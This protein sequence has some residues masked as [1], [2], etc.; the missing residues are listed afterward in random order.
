MAKS[1]RVRGSLRCSDGTVVPIYSRR[2]L[3]AIRERDDESAR[4]SA[5]IASLRGELEGAR[6]NERQLEAAWKR[7][8][9]SRWVR[10]GR[11]LGMVD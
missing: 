4:M 3:D 9:G 5:H 7:L 11:W 10:L 2:V 6:L 1:V 8:D